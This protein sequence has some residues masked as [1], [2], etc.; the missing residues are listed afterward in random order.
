[1]HGNLKGVFSM[2]FLQ[3]PHSVSQ[4]LSVVPTPYWILMLVLE[5]YTIIAALSPGPPGSILAVKPAH[6]APESSSRDN[7]WALLVASQGEWDG[8]CW[9]GGAGKG[10]P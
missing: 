6:G 5:T 4:G 3:C 8:E 1:M 10:W 9:C 7:L 2:L